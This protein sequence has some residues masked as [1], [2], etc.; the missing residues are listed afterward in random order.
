[1]TTHVVLL[2]VLEELTGLST[3]QNTSLK[4]EGGMKSEKMN[5]RY[6][7]EEMTD[8]YARVSAVYTHGDDR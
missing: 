1:M 3:G 8:R 6:A 2:S 4:G 5:A 7:R